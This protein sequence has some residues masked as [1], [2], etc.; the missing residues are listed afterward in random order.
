[1]DIKIKNLNEC[2]LAIE[3]TRVCNDNIVCPMNEIKFCPFGCEV[4]C[5]DVTYNDWLFV[6]RKD[7][8]GQ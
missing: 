2:V 3:L 7:S 1:M 6:I 4:Q 8:T 5:T